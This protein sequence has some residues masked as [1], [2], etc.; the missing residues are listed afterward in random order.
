MSE[1]VAE[2]PQE[3]QRPETPPMIGPA[4]HPRAAMLIRR[5]KGWGGMGG[6]FLVASVSWMQGNVLFDV[7]VRGLMG[8]IAGY[9]IAWT[10]AVSIGRSLL[11]AQGQI[12]VERVLEVRRKQIA[13]AAE[14]ARKMAEEMGLELPEAVE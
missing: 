6:F 4:D 10:A 5:A 14:A 13:E 3:A 7:C 2:Q 8:G 11:K 1:A 12:A 9:L